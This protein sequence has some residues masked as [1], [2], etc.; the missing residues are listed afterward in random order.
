MNAIL[1][2][3]RELDDEVSFTPEEEVKVVAI[4]VI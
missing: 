2:C 4:W 3:F 1:L